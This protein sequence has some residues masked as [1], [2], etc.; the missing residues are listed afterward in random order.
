MVCTQCGA[1]VGWR[2]QYC[3]ACGAQLSSAA[4][5]QEGPMQALPPLKYAGFWL[6]AAAFLLD[7]LLLAL[8]YAAVEAV[9]VAV[10]GVFMHLHDWLPLVFFGTS[11]LLLTW[12]WYAAFESSPWQATPGKKLLRLQVTT[13]QGG[14]VSF[15]RALGRQAG[16]VVSKFL[17]GLGYLFAAF[18]RRK[19]ALHDM[20]ASTLV[21]RRPTLLP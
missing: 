4:P 12:C 8:V 5:K 20:F 21:V 18:T 9:L 10:F 6:R 1:K 13:L 3:M 14:R 16:K 15:W 11:G 2:H 7:S 17:F 19:Q